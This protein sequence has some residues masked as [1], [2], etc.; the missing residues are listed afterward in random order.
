[1]VDI[2]CLFWDI[3]DDIYEIY[4]R[5]YILFFYILYI[6]YI[7]ERV[8]GNLCKFLLQGFGSLDFFIYLCQS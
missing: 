2:L 6:I 3:Y 5:I 4:I 8:W 7:L 1:M